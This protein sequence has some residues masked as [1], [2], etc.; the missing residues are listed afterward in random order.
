VQDGSD[1]QTPLEMFSDLIEPGVQ[2][3]RGPAWWMDLRRL[4]DDMARSR[5]ST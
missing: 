5:P 3:F 2:R 4:A 1:V